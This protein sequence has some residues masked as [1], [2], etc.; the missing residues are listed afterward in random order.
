MEAIAFSCEF[1]GSSPNLC[2]ERTN[3]GG[4]GIPPVQF[5][6]INWRRRKEGGCAT[7]KPSLAKRVLS[8]YLP[9]RNR[10]CERLHMVIGSYMDE[11]FDTKQSGVFVVGG[12]LGRSVP[13]FELERR[14]EQLRKRPD[15]DIEY[16]KASECQRGSGQ[17]SKFVADSHNVT[18]AER[19]KLDSISH[20]FLA[21]IAQPA[22]FDSTAYI[23]AQGVGILQQDFYDVIK[24]P[25]ARALLGSSPY[26][27]AYDFAM[28]QCA[29]AMKQLG[30]GYAVS[31]VC[32]EHE[33]YSPLAYDAYRNLKQ[34]NPDAAQYM[35]TFASMDD[36][37]CEPLQAADAAVFEIRRALNLSLGHWEG[38]LRKQFS[39]LADARSMFLITHSNKEQLQHI[40][41][42]HQ[43][44][45]PFKLDALMELQLTEN[46]TLRI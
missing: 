9:G 32:D 5:N 2:A 36:K 8:P 13:F 41:A 33:Q 42:T 23:C 1:V 18:L 27:L 19:A 21:L 7:R 28:I 22:V 44:G 12:L 43:P 16:F 31:F 24:D 46:I 29:W 45:E 35:T 39:I 3:T 38:E 4:Y 37:K 20:E 25:K 14:W 10:Y 11:S 15:I 40:V 34:T 6:G 30:N 26:R 17:F